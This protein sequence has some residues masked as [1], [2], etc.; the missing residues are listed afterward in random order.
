MPAS[1]RESSIIDAH[2]FSTPA[3]KYLR[4]HHDIR[5][6]YTCCEI[7]VA[8]TRRRNRRP[9]VFLELSTNWERNSS[10][11]VDGLLAVEQVKNKAVETPIGLTFVDLVLAVPGN[12][13]AQIGIPVHFARRNAAAATNTVCGVD[14]STCASAEAICAI[15]Q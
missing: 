2:P 9:H 12:I 3:A 5:S 1:A 4:T 14:G 11:Q 15:R 7:T 6:K 10:C 13:Q 8:G